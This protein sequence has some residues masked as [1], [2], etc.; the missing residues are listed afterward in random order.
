MAL[1]A[2]ADQVQWASQVQALLP[3]R[4]VLE[5]HRPLLALLLHMQAAAAVAPHPEQQVRAAP[6]AVAGVLL[7]RRRE[8]LHRFLTP[9]AAAAAGAILPPSM[10]M[11]AL[12]E[13]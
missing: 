4:V 11:L 6:V 8:L 9:V 13:L 12:M 7:P 2:A 5:L 1:A 10:V 3:V